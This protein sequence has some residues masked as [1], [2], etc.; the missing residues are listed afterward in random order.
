[1]AVGEHVDGRP[2]DGFP[3]PRND[4]GG[5]SIYKQTTARN[6]GSSVE[7]MDSGT[8]GTTKAI[9]PGIGPL[10]LDKD[11]YPDSIFLRKAASYNGGTA[12]LVYFGGS[13][14]SGSTTTSVTLS[15][16]ENKFS[17]RCAVGDLNGDGALDIAIVNIYFGQKDA[18]LR[19]PGRKR[20]WLCNAVVHRRIR[21]RH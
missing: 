7:L 16:N 17:A 12:D 4:N 3:S 10:D 19:K 20:V 2:E 15:G 1:M 13:S 18:V 8:A 11:G 14:T 5:F 6:F 9:C 21:A